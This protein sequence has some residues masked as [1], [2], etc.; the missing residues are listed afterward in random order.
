MG[1]SKVFLS[2]VIPAYNESNRIIRSLNKIV[3]Y[4]KTRNTSCEVIIVNDG[5]KD[6]TAEVVIDF[7]KK[8]RDFRIISYNKNKGKGYATKKGVLIAKGS[9]ILFTD[10]DL[11]APIEE[12]DN[13]MKHATKGYDF[14]FGSRGM[15]KRKIK[16]SQ[17]FYRRLFAY[18]AKIY[19]HIVLFTFTKAPKDAQCGFKLFTKKSA[20]LLFK[21]QKVD[22]GIFD[23]EI[24]YLAKKFGIK[25]KEVPVV[26]INNPD[27]KIN[28]VKCV[29][30]DP[31][32][33]IKIRIWDFQGRYD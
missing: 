22:G 14:V 12:L 23:S 21:K 33:L 29:L 11:S 2:I 19:V 1:K 15:D 30:F 26:W 18:L 5:S 4:I 9:Y 27:S 17:P 6:K 32:D 3:N 20:H 25:M 13:L 24:I 28:F 7:A 16:V 10:A 31:I 8:H